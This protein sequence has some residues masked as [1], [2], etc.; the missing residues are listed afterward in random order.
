MTSLMHE[1]INYSLLQFDNY[2]F[3]LLELQS[4]CHKVTKVFVLE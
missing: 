4:Q 3:R 1:F 2:V